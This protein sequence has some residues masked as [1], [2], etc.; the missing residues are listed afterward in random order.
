MVTTGLG[1]VGGIGSPLFGQQLGVFLH[2]ES[3][4]G[5]TI[6]DGLS[7]AG[8]ALQLRRVEA[9][10]VRLIGRLDYQRVR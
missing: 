6:F 10:V 5:Q 3:R 7:A 8:E 1:F 2:A 9:E 4:L